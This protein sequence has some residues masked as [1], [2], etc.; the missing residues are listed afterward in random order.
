IY[1][2]FCDQVPI[3]MIAGN[4][5]DE[6]ERRPNADWQHSAHDQGIIVR[7]MTKWDDQ[8]Y[9]MQGFNESMVRAYDIATSAPQAPVLIVASGEWMENEL[10][11]DERKKLFVPKLKERTPPQGEIGAVREAAKWLV[12]A[13][14]PVII[15]DRYA[16]TP[17]AMPLLVQLAELL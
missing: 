6:G 10:P 12:Q 4:T 7:D 8:P 17:K 3:V 11:P 13:E 1:N 2:A 9:S 5:E 15:A 14:N 16:R